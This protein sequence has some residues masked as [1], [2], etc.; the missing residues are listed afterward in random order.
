MCI[1]CSTEAFYT[2]GLYI[3]Y[4]QACAWC[5]EL[6]ALHVHCK[7]SFSHV[8]LKQD[9]YPAQNIQKYANSMNNVFCYSFTK[10]ATN[11]VVDVYGDGEVAI[12]YRHCMA[13]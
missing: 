11:L 7:V 1:S 13:V 4:L 2:P 10:G 6:Y 3:E 5:L 12:S 9:L 8:V